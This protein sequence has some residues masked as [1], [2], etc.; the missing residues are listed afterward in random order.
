METKNSLNKQMITEF[1]TPAELRL[2]RQTER[3]WN[4]NWL[5]GKVLPRRQKFEQKKKVLFAPVTFMRRNHL[6]TPSVYRR[7]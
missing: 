1:C 6:R 3:V 5:R 7:H 4:R 2:C